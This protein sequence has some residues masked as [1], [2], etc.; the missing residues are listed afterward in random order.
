MYRL[1]GHSEFHFLNLCSKVR[2]YTAGTIINWFQSMAFP[3]YVYTH[4]V[5]TMNS[6]IT[7]MLQKLL[8]L[9][10]ME[11]LGKVLLFCM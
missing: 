10:K 9:E 4:T 2:K 5:T 11:T 8:L 3:K 6:Q 7:F 1:K